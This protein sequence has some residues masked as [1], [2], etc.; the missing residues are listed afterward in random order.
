MVQHIQTRCY[1]LHKIGGIEINIAV[2]FL[3]RKMEYGNEEAWFILRTISFAWF[4]V[5]WNAGHFP[6]WQ[7][8]NPIYQDHW[9]FFAAYP[10]D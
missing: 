3:N 5:P 4:D 7:A 2:F 1:L 10:V 6:F 9:T 8:M